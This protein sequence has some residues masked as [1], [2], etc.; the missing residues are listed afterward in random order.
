MLSALFCFQYVEVKSFGVILVTNGLANGEM[1]SLV[2][3]EKLEMSVSNQS[4]PKEVR[5]ADPLDLLFLPF[6]ALAGLY[7]DWFVV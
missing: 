5:V 1:L 4:I 6:D 7:V 2:Q 3:C